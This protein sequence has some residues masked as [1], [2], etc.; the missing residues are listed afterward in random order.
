VYL[1]LRVNEPSS[2]LGVGVVSMYWVK[3]SGPLLLETGS[4]MVPR[5][6]K[7]LRRFFRVV[8]VV[9]IAHCR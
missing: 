2:S 9:F 3:Q 6:G 4:R 7:K 1:A 5:T 8:F